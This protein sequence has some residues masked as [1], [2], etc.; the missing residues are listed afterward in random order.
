[1][2]HL[3]HQIEI[4]ASFFLSNAISHIIDPS[5]LDKYKMLKIHPWHANRINSN[6]LH[7]FFIRQV[8][9]ETHDK[10]K[11][12]GSQSS[13]NGNWGYP[14]KW[15]FEVC[16]FADVLVIFL[17]LNKLLPWSKWLFCDFCHA[18]LWILNRSISLYKCSQRYQKI[19]Y[20]MFPKWWNYHHRKPVVFVLTTPLSKPKIH[21]FI[22]K[23]HPS[24]ILFANAS[25][26]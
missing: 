2:V 4:A 20:I 25:Y 21:P 22:S 18:A 6:F 24:I 5:S 10:K 9:I 11:W 3:Y 12:S 26:M 19:L 15:S 8:Y 14:I 7:K 16:V 17:L 13:W 1:M 23:L